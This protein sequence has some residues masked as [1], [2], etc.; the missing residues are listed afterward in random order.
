MKLQAHQLATQAKAAQKAGNV[1]KASAL[2]K[3]ALDLEPNNLEL[4]QG[5]AR[6]L[7]AQKNYLEAAQEFH[8]LHV[9]YPEEIGLWRECAISYLH[10]GEFDMATKFLMKWVGKKPDDY[11]AWMNLCF[12]AGSTAKHSDALFYAMQAMQLKPLEAASHN[13]LGSVLLT[14]GRLNDALISFDT[15]LK[16]Q[17]EMM[18][19]L[20]NV[21]TTFSQLG[22][23]HRAIDLYRQCLAKLP[24]RDD[25]AETLKY[26]M[27]FDLLKTGDLK[28]GWECYDSGFVPADIR[29]RNPK[30]R[31]KVPLWD[32]RKLEGKT[33]LIWR[34]QGLGDELMFLSTLREARERCDSIIVECD[35]RL[36]GP[37]TRSF[38]DIL[39]RAQAFVQPPS[40][41]SVHEDFDCHIPMGSLM[42]IFRSALGDF[43]RAGAYIVPDPVRRQWFAD[44]L[45]AFPHRTKVGISWRSGMLNVERNSS[46]LPISDLEPVLRMPNVDF[47]NLQYGDCAQEIQNVADHFGVTIHQMPD[48]DLRNDLDGVFALMS[49]LDHVITAKTAVSEM[50]PAVGAPTS[51]FMPADSWTLFGQ[52]RY[53]FY[54]RVE[55]FT[56]ATGEAMIDVIPRMAE[57]LTKRFGLTT[58]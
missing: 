1:A 52:D 27:S 46:Y 55:A 26:R 2:L 24:P 18:D 6:M 39:F 8:Q 10:L 17:P 22:D 51:V 14:M 43:D 20:S 29:S 16:L 34:E 57:T 30:R 37:L 49:C 25:F 53:V 21:A 44:R 33:L 19:A 5:R 58:S 41:M 40:L 15:A 9:S 36:I 32:G 7:F 31:F 48:L 45:A 38:P 13:N 28:N 56:P 42:R 35:P 47:V 3:R 50:A 11:E 54:P 4:R 23:S 12:A